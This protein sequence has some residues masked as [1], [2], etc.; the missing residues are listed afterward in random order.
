VLALLTAQLLNLLGHRLAEPAEAY[1]DIQGKRLPW[2][3]P[4]SSPSALLHPAPPK[5]RTLKVWAHSLQM[6]YSH[7]LGG[8]E[9]MSIASHE[10]QGSS[11]DV[12]GDDATRL[13]DNPPELLTAEEAARLLRVRPAWIYAHARE[14]G[15]W[16]LLGERGPWRFSRRRLLGE[17]ENGTGKRSAA[18]AARRKRTGA[19]G[20]PSTSLLP[21]R[22]RPI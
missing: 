9:L 6:G 17:V 4:T 2:P 22:Q 18:P 12:A 10:P 5:G 16:R 7:P 3:P 20:S 13:R 1:S 19:W 8:N 14:L 15:G 21:I 11:H